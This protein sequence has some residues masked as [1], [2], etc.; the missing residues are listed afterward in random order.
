MWLDIF[1]VWETTG[2][3]IQFFVSSS[4]T[5]CYIDNKH[6]PIRHSTQRKLCLNASNTKVRPRSL[7]LVSRIELNNLKAKPKETRVVSQSLLFPSIAST[8]E[9]PRQTRIGLPNF[10]L[11][12]MHIKHFHWFTRKCSPSYR[13]KQHHKKKS[14]LANINCSRFGNFVF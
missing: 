7:T 8:F 11:Q 2:D 13:F 9:Y 12:D 5:Y 1:L 10:D 4:S 14:K 6:F 3:K